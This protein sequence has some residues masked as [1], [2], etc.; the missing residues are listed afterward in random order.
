MFVVVE[1]GSVDVFKRDVVFFGVLIYCVIGRNFVDY[2]GYGCY[3]GL[4]GKGRFVD[5][6]DW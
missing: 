4:G 3:C 2:N 1:E 6:L 5:K